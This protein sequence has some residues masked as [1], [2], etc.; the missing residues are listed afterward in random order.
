MAAINPATHSTRQASMAAPIPLSSK[1][2]TTP[3]SIS[4]DLADGEMRVPQAAL[5]LKVLNWDRGGLPDDA[6]A[7]IIYGPRG[8]TLRILAYARPVLCEGV[9]SAVIVFACADEK[10]RLIASRRLGKISGFGAHGETMRQHE[11]NNG[12]PNGVV[13]ITTTWDQRDSLKAMLLATLEHDQALQRMVLR[14]V[15]ESERAELDTKV[16]KTFVRKGG[17]VSRHFSGPRVKKYRL[18]DFRLVDT[19]HLGVGTHFELQFDDHELM[20]L[21]L[22]RYQQFRE[23]F[24]D[25]TKPCLLTLVEAAR[26]SQDA[27]NT[28]FLWGNLS[29]TLSAGLNKHATRLQAFDYLAMVCG[30]DGTAIP[31]SESLWSELS[32]NNGYPASFE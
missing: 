22:E 28:D 25:R 31:L 30:L 16:L 17:G 8:A 10:T 21:A 23:Q 12:G 14:G 1:G 26:P 24:E 11:Q 4:G 9:P 2:F 13:V 27:P 15:L 7:T 5:R 18:S 6:S 3:R 20:D 29:F 32:T 19:V